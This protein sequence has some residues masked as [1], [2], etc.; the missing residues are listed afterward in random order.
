MASKLTAVPFTTVK[1]QVA[2]L[3]VHT[4][5]LPAK[6]SVTMPV[7][8]RPCGRNCGGVGLVF[9]RRTS[10]LPAGTGVSAKVAVTVCCDVIGTTHAP[11]PVQAP[12]Q[13]T[14]VAP[15]PVTAL[16]ARLRLLESCAEQTPGQPIT[17]AVSLAT[18]PLPETR[19]SSRFSL[20]RGSSPAWKAA[21]PATSS[22]TP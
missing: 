22:L 12:P 9:T 20:G 19:T 4:T 21:L 11:V 15:V 3:S 18:L 14:N 6:R 17:P 2:P 16:R 8:S 5:V 1:L 13:P 10:E 7:P